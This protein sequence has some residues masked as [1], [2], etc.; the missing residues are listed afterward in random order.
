MSVLVEKEYHYRLS[1]RA[2]RKIGRLDNIIDDRSL[3]FGRQQSFF[4]E[5]GDV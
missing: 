1:I 3:W 5:N 4:I 2:I